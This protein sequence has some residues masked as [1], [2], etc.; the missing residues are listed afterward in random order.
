MAATAGGEGSSATAAVEAPVD[1]GL[2]VVTVPE[3]AKVVVNDKETQASGTTRY[4]V[5]RGMTKDKSYSFEVKMTAEEDG[6]PQVKTRKVSLAAG[7]R[8]TVSFEGDDAKDAEPKKADAKADAKDTP[9]DAKATAAP[10]AGRHGSDKTT[11]NL[12]L[13]VPA[14]ATVRLQ[15]KPTTTEGTERAYTTTTLAAG[16]R[17]EDYAVEVTIGAQTVT[18]RVTLVGGEVTTLT[19]D[20]ATIAAAELET[21][22][23]IR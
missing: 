14:N 7:E 17:R 23:A 11:T 10:S 6:K 1:G 2:L 8:K 13:V 22:V 9:T 4:F 3:G 16:E 18:R 5:S 19:I 21:G 15:G 20:P 12:I